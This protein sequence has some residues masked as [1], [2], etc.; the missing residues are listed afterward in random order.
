MGAILLLEVD[1][2]RHVVEYASKRFSK[3]QLRY[4]IIEKEATAIMFALNKWEHYLLGSKFK[5]ET[6]H[7]PLEWLRTKGDCRGKLGRMALRLEEFERFNINYIPGSKN[8]DAD[9]L[10]RIVATVSISYEEEDDATRNE[11]PEWFDTDADGQV[12]YVADGTRRKW[13]PRN[14]RRQVLIDQKSTRLNSSHVSI[15][16]VVFCLKKERYY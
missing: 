13:I 9:A 5:I 1:G 7:K 16:Y 2:Q 12:W 14:K 11:H 6:D 3:A 15:S 8:A 4:P 10:S